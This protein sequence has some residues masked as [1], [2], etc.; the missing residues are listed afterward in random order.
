MKKKLALVGILSLLLFSVTACANNIDPTKIVPNNLG[1]TYEQLDPGTAAMRAP[2]G[3]MPSQEIGVV[4]D[5]TTLVAYLGGS[6]SCPPTID[7]ID[8]TTGPNVQ[9]TLKPDSTSSCTTDFSITA[10]QITAVATNFDFHKKAV[11]ICKNGSCHVLPI[12]TTTTN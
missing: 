2:G 5:N 6:S 1:F 9:I 11:S 10:F 3:V 8:N 7:H 12:S 4:Q